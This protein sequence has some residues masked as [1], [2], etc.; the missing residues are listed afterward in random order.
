MTVRRHIRRLP[1]TD[2]DIPGF[3]GNL[4]L[5]VPAEPFGTF[6]AVPSSYCLKLRLR[7]E[8][9][10]DGGDGG[11]GDGGGGCVG[12]AACAAGCGRH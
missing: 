11:G 12:L 6:P 2:A 9:L 8:A 4:H 3:L 5:H 10:V 7:E 1:L